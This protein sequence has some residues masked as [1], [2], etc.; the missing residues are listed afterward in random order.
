MV[1][2]TSDGSP[3]WCPSCDVLG[4]IQLVP[5]RD[6]HSG[7]RHHK[8]KCTA[9]GY[10]IDN[11]GSD[12]TRY[13]AADEWQSLCEHALQVKKHLF[14]ATKMGKQLELDVNAFIGLTGWFDALNAQPV[15]S[16]WYNVRRKISDEEREAR[17]PPLQRRW[18]NGRSES[19]SRPV[20]VGEEM[21]AE[22]IDHIKHREATASLIDLE[23]QGLTGPHP[24][25]QY[26]K[27]RIRIVE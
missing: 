16:G 11:L 22:D 4:R 18:W 26:E 12:G 7:T 5:Y 24:E 25:L 14:G 10:S 19:F 3:L 27:P 20:T 17:N 9:C 23:W 8:A 2:T 13:K 21:S 15:L 6:L 1:S